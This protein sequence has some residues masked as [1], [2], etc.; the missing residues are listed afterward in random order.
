MYPTLSDLLFDLFG[1]NIPLPIQSF[2]FF[3]AIAFIACYQVL[4]LEMNGK[5][6]TD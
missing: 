3:V 1:V 2:G 6:M 4:T 5:N